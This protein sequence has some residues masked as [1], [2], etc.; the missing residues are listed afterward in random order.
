MEQIDAAKAAAVWQRVRQDPAEGR[1]WNPA[2]LEMM[3]TEAAAVFGQLAR[4]L[5]AH[6][7]RLQYIAEE[8]RRHGACLR[9]ILFL[10]DGAR[11]GAKR[12]TP[13]SESPALA[14]RK[15]Y[16]NALRT[17]AGYD[18]GREDPEF[19][20]VFSAMAAKKREHCAAILEI[21]G[22]ISK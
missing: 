17:A 3:E 16:G 4:Q 13:A 10:I 15:C 22:Q 1:P 11:P 6:R 8:C 20:C 2:A 12:K 5:P 21:L 19:G 9:G 14:L 7:A 18:A